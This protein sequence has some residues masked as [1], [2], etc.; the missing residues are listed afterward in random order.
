MGD[1]EA[2]IRAIRLAQVPRAARAAREAPE[3]PRLPPPEQR[4]RAPLS[5]EEI[6]RRRAAYD[7]GTSQQDIVRVLDGLRQLRAGMS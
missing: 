2:Q 1:L 3:E 7:S 5:P 6:V 4:R